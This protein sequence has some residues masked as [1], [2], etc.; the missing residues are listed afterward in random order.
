MKKTKKALCPL[1]SMPDTHKAKGYIGSCKTHGWFVRSA[2]DGEPSPHPALVAN[3]AVLVALWIEHA[4]AVQDFAFKIEATT[5]QREAM[6]A[7]YSE[8]S[9]AMTPQSIKGALQEAFHAGIDRG[10]EIAACRVES[11]AFAGSDVDTIACKIRALKGDK[12]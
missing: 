4:D 1:C 10:L 11:D 3:H 8:L 5:E 9:L 2:W 7:Q 6:V 12:P